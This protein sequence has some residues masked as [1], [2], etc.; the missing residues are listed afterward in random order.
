LH[1]LERLISK[2][3]VE[4]IPVD[5]EH[6]RLARFAFGRFGKGRH[7]A[8]LNYGDC[9]AYAAAIALGELLLCKG[10]DFI[11]TDAPVFDINDK[12]TI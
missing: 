2:A 12:R 9:F 11:H 4:L 1:D 5:G 6:G 3:D 7:R 10:N 8:C